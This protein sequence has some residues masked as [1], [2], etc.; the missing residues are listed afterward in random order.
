[1][2]LR[3][4]L[5]GLAAIIGAA[6]PAQADPSATDPG[7]DTNFLGQLNQAGISYSNGPAAVAAARTAC[8]MMDSG[9]KE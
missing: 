8:D 6:V 9:Q 7:L 3:V 5:A 4:V 1:M 2:R